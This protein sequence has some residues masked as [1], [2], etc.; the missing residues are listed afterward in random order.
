MLEC[1]AADAQQVEDRPVEDL[2]N[3]CG[4]ICRAAGDQPSGMAIAG[5]EK[6]HQYREGGEGEELNDDVGPQVSRSIEFAQIPSLRL[7]WI[8]RDSSRSGKRSP[9]VVR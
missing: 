2:K 7:C 6:D 9:T 8:W 3:L 5:R 4:N 1:M